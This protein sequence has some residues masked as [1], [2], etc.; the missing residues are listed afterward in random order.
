MLS[1]LKWS[2]ER[3]STSHYVLRTASTSWIFS[4][5]TTPILNFWT[6]GYMISYLNGGNMQKLWG[7][8][9]P[10]CLYVKHKFIHLKDVFSTWA[11]TEN[12]NQFTSEI[13]SIGKYGRGKFE[14]SRKWTR[15]LDELH[16][17]SLVNWKAVYF[18][19][20]EITFWTIKGKE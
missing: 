6:S 19:W 4:I 16:W 11:L 2:F 9:H 14:S 10:S 12:K 15:V 1:Y 5:T 17:W 3:Y 8:N 20:L 18:A 7:N 13:K